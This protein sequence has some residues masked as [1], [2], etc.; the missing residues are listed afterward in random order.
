MCLFK[1]QQLENLAAG[2]KELEGTGGAIGEG[3]MTFKRQGRKGL[4]ERVR[5]HLV[6]G[7]GEETAEEAR[8]RLLGLH[9]GSRGAEN[10]CLAL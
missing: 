3:G 10:E 9:R 1:A 2:S 6:G 7:V 4:T 5:V 8:G